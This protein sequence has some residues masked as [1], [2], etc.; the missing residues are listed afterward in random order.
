MQFGWIVA[1]PGSLWLGDGTIV[2]NFR[3]AHVFH[4]PE[5]AK[6][7]ARRAFPKGNLTL[8]YLEAQP[9]QGTTDTGDWQPLDSD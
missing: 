9:V 1:G 3:Q 4:D 7:Q 5:Y 6:S 2:R 8:Y